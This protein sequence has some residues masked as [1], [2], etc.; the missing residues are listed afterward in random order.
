M[1]LDYLRLGK[2]LI[3]L[4]TILTPFSVLPIYVTL[5]ARMPD[6]R[7]RQALRKTLV[8][9]LI[10]L[11]FFQWTGLY[12][13]RVLGIELPSFQIAGGLIIASIAWSML[14]ANPSR[15][16]TTHTEDEEGLEKED[17]SIV[18]LAIPMLSGPGAITT[19]ILLSQQQKHLQGD[20]S[21]TVLIVVSTAL[22]YPVF[23]LAHPLFKRL[24]VTGTRI[25]TRIMGMLLL[26][27]AVE[28]IVKGVIHSF[29]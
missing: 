16:Q 27:I 13:F 12:V 9:V 19:V 14:H 11:L 6:V 8:T 26:A 1:E 7:R 15:I 18:P 23:R 5:T 25:L 20:L 10:T 21:L 4:L 29:T 2:E 17:F 22:L 3:S 28:F 24:G